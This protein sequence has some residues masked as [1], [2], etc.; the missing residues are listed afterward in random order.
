MQSDLKLPETGLQLKM[1]VVINNLIGTGRSWTEY[2]LIHH[3]PE[4]HCGS[5]HCG[6]KFTVVN[7]RMLAAFATVKRIHLLGPKNPRF[8]SQGRPPFELPIAGREDFSKGSVSLVSCDGNSHEPRASRP[9]VFAAVS[10]EL[11][12]MAQAPGRWRKHPP[13]CRPSP[14]VAKVLEISGDIWR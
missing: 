11:R 8:G 13:C 5:F 14:R 4:A 6:S 10:T 7:P 3:A 12:K 9:K 2:S 1:I